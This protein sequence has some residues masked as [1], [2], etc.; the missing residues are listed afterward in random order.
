[1]YQKPVLKKL[2]FK[3]LKACMGMTAVYGIYKEHLIGC[4]PNLGGISVANMNNG[5]RGIHLP[6]VKEAKSF[7]DR[8]ISEHYT[9]ISQ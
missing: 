9:Y 5:L 8:T 7:I 4:C 2:E 3:K 1:M 6:S